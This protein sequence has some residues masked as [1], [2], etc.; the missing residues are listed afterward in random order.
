MSLKTG[1]QFLI[2]LAGLFAVGALITLVP[3]QAV[4]A[5]DL[6]YLSL[7]PFAPWSTLI[8][9]MVAGICLGLRNYR[10]SRTK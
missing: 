9:L 5:N 10:L 2:A 4:L 7:C 1:N 3:A 6:G 8:L